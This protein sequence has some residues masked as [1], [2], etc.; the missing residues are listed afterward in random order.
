[1]CTVNVGD[2][3]IQRME[4][5]NFFLALLVNEARHEHGPNPTDLPRRP[6]VML[7]FG[8]IVR[9]IFAR[10]CCG[11]RYGAHNRDVVGQLRPEEAAAVS[12]LAA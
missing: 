9:T 10:R 5:G 12:H 8:L 4:R 3:L 11:G 2:E 1:M 6:V 7:E